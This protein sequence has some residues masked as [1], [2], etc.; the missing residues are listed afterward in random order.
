MFYRQHGRCTQTGT[1]TASL[2]M[3]FHQ[4]YTLIFSPSG[5][6]DCSGP[7]SGL[8][9]KHY[10]RHNGPEGWVYFTSLNTNLDQIS[11]SE[12][13]PG[14]NFKISTKHQDLDKSKIKTLTK[15][16]LRILTK[17]QLRNL[18]RRQQQNTDQTS[19]SK[20]CLN[21]NF[22]IF[23]KPWNLVLKVWTKT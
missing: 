8:N 14:I 13:R 3:H 16:S 7:R 20:Y 19:A 22:E 15:P 12:S 2:S 18:N 21:I 11:S 1:I 10:Q 6:W 5:L 4:V 17:I 9:L 23:T